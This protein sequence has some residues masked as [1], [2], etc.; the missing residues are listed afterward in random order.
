M[1]YIVT[2]TNWDGIYSYTRLFK[3]FCCTRFFKVLFLLFS[4]ISSLE[5][6][7]SLKASIFFSV[8]MRPPYGLYFRQFV[9]FTNI[10]CSNFLP[11]HRTPEIY[12]EYLNR[13]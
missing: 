2:E 4:S 7:M 9:V 8:T 10:M 6:A 13:E 1:K 11:F 5:G 12:F 3:V